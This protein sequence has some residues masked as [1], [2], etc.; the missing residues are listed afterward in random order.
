MNYRTVSSQPASVGRSLLVSLAFALLFAGT[1]AAQ[2]PVYEF[3]RQISS[4]YYTSATDASGNIYK[5]GGFFGTVDFNPGSGTANLT[6][7]SPGSD[8]YLAKYT[9]SGNYVWAFR[10]GVSN[11]ANGLCHVDCF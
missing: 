5:A 1:A 4:G 9:S 10:V 3:A 2:S 8:I 11:A 6:S 7:Y